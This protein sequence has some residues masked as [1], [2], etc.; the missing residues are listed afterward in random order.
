MIVCFLEGFL[1]GIFPTISKG[2]RESPKILGVANAFSAGVFLAIALIHIL[3]EEVE[4]WDNIMT[5]KGI[6]DPFPLPYLMVF[7]GYT[8]ILILEKVLF[9][10]PNFDQAIVDE[11][12]NVVDPAQDKLINAVRASMM[13]LDRPSMDTKD[14]AEAR[15]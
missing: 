3:P 13:A 1:S 6:D 7:L 14:E 2:C 5:E 15:N 10:K 8:L 4:G 12:G 11:K 9:D